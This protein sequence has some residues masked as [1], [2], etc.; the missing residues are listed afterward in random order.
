MRSIAVVGCGYWG[1]NLVRN[2]D[3]LGVLALVCEK[4]ETGRELA[5]QFAPGVP[6]AEDIST[7]FT[8]PIT[9]V[10]I[11]TPAETHHA[12]VLEFLR[13]GKDVFCEKPLA[14]TYAQGQE[15]VDAA[16]ELSRI[17]M[18]GHLLEH[19]P[20]ILRLAELVRS[21]ELGALR[22]IHSSRLSL[23]K[24]RREEDV[25]WSFAPHDIS[26]IL[27]LMGCLPVQVSAV[28]GSYV[29]PGIADAATASLLF[30]SGVRAHISLSWLHPFKEQRLVVIGSKGAASYDDVSKELIRYDQRV[31]IIDGAPVPVKGDAVKL[32]FPPDEPLRL[33]CAAFLKAISTREQ[34]A[35]DGESG[36]R[37]LQVLQAAQH[38]LSCGGKPVDLSSEESA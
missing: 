34:P 35:T 9:G 16:R 4:T 2:L 26:V 3:Q 17:L 13:A 18:V 27:R 29:Q 14:T 25:L 12:L 36:L 23:G 31:D 30:E 11:A 6:V 32:A 28:G 37:V 5:A 20:G 38:S 22:Y 15:M 24:I 19:H 1:K 10:V 21:G 7:A 8:D 33:E